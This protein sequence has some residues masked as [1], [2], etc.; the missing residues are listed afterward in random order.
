M[1]GSDELA[2]H[3]KL[4]TAQ[5]YVHATG[6]D[7]ET[8]S[9]GF[10]AAIDRTV[11]ASVLKWRQMFQPRVR[12]GPPWVLAALLLVACGG[13][14][15]SQGDDGNE[16]GGAGSGGRA[17]GGGA[18][19]RGGSGGLPAQCDGF[20]NESG[21]TILVQLTNGTAR[22]LYLGARTAGCGL[23]STFS[24]SDSSGMTLEG[25]QF[26]ASSCQDI[27][28]AAVI[29]CPPIACIVSS[30]VTLQP[31]ESFRQ[32]WHGV[33]MKEEL[34]PAGCTQSREAITC[35]RVA[36]IQAGP[37]TFTASAATGID[38]SPFGDGACT[39]CVAD[40]NGGCTTFG[41]IAS[42][43]SLPAAVSVQL[44]PSLGVDPNDSVPA[45]GLVF[46]E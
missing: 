17:S 24:V 5:R 38:C 7:V 43:R 16:A 14:S 4:H 37:F 25:P 23:G 45:V 42:G 13:K 21:P 6:A 41:A 32:E 2:G 12:R 27:A 1:G 29:S 22:S 8:R 18:N 15:Q 26:C 33:Y 11:T 39:A 28:R 20:P 9:G 36:A 44:D 19:N 31:G 3:S 10:P 34:L 35:S 30:V 46:Q 40:S